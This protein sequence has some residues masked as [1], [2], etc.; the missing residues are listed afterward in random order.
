VRALN[1]WRR[2]ETA[3]WRRV[4]VSRGITRQ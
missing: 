4:I 1:A 2:T 3:H